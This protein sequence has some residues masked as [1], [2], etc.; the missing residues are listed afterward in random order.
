MSRTTI[1]SSWTAPEQPAY[2]EKALAHLATGGAAA[3]GGRSVGEQL[4]GLGIG[5]AVAGGAQLAQHRLD[6]GEERLGFLAGEVTL[7]NHPATGAR[8]AASMRL[9]SS[10][11]SDSETVRSCP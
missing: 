6:F 2:R 3:V 9:R 1:P 4:M 5:Q 11:A 7:V 8:A 10:S